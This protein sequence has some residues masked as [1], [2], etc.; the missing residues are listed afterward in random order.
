MR[1]KMVCIKKA[2]PCYLGLFVIVR[3]R[4][5]VGTNQNKQAS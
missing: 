5:A 1:R 3:S 4:M 2:L